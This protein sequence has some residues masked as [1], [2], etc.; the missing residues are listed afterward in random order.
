MDD[1]P[2]TK[3]RRLLAE[4]QHIIGEKD[5]EIARLTAELKRHRMTTAERQV[6]F[7][8]TRGTRGCLREYL[9][10]TATREEE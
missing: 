3:A 6:L 2:L 4:S 10:R 8:A 9:A 7:L 1:D 5:K